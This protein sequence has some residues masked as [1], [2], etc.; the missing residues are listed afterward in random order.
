MRRVPRADS[1]LRRVGLARALSKRGLCSRSA[2][3]ALI[4]A[5]KVSLDGQIVRNPEHPTLDT[6]RI[7][8]AG[9]T[10]KPVTR[11][12]LML[13][14]P[15][16]LVTTAQDE[17]A[18]HTVYE[19]FRDSGLPWMGPVG[20]LDKASEGLLLFSNDTEWAA[21]LLDPANHLPRTYHVQV[22]GIPQPE[23]LAA[24]KAGIRT[25][26]GEHLAVLDAHLLRQGTRN[27]W[28]SCVLDEGRNRHLRRLCEALGFPVL[29]LVRVAFGPLTLGELQKGHWRPLTETERVALGVS[30]Q[31]T[32]RA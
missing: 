9:D 15:R 7:E 4:L 31:A 2:A 19:C 6:S 14:K 12:Y 16:G 13:N 23:T 22:E 24:L 18:R 3:T 1:G 30:P 32:D 8:V 17:Q 27:A 20:R 29:R 11:Q 28:L 5:G 26:E 21:R 10:L 25:P